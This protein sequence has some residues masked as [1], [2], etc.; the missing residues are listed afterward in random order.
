MKKLLCAS[1]FTLLSSALTANAAVS[2]E[3]AARLGK[4]LTPLGAERAGNAD[5]SIPEWNPANLVIPPDFEPGSDHYPDPYRDEKPLY[6]V[7]VENWRDYSDILTEGTQGLFEKLGPDG[8]KMNVY[9]TKRTAEAPDWVY[10]NARKNATN[11]RLV[12]DGQKIEGNLPGTPF[13]IPQSGLE[14]L[15]NH[16]VRYAE[17][18]SQTYDVYYV[19]SNGSPILSTTAYATAVYPAFETPDEEVGDKPWAKLRINY[20]A[21]A[22]RAGEILLVHEPGADYT[23]GKGRRAWQYLVGQRRVRLAPAVAF[24]TPNPAV[25]GTSTYDDAGIWNGSPERY[26][27]KLLGKKEILI[28]AS[29]Y[30]FLFEKK[31]EDLLGEKF[32]SP[33]FVRWEKHRV[34]VVEGTL[35][36]GLRHLYTKRRMYVDEDTWVVAAGETYDGKGNLWRVSFAYGARLYD[37]KSGAGATGSYD[38]L[39]NIYNLNGKPIPGKFEN[40][41]DKNSKY[42]TPKGLSRG[43]VR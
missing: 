9:P 20:K 25:A 41:V 19:G 35:K 32:L 29:N 40:G 30:A 12:E 24:D 7:D 2:P 15:W 31:V 3:E 37:R 4:D 6:T 36:D 42:F 34:W 16:M 26:N 22:R 14:V 38:L 18:F 43:G 27:W 11:A 23:E 10:A 1:C 13:P 8:F 39:Q 33:E 28:P 5:G 17:P 21:P